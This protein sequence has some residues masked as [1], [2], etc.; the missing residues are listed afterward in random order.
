MKKLC[1]CKAQ[2]NLLLARKSDKTMDSQI[3]LG[4]ICSHSL[5][6]DL[7]I[8]ASQE[9]YRLRFRREA[10]GCWLAMAKAV[11]KTN[12]LGLPSRGF[13][14]NVRT[15]ELSGDFLQSEFR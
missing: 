10:V 3:M 11:N 15:L 6:Y 4:H 8:R 5:K 7:L 9:E 14:S 12:L 1:G 2:Q 13:G